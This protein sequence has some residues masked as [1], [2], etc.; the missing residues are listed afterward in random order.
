M[1]RLIELE[2]VEGANPIQ[3]MLNYVNMN[4]MVAIQKLLML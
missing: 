3:M 4:D 2:I 1:F